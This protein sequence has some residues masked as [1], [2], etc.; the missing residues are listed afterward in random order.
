MSTLVTQLTKNITNIAEFTIQPE[1]IIRAG[2]TGLRSLKL[3]EEELS[4]VRT[5]FLHA[6]ANSLITAFALAVVALPCAYVLQ[7]KMLHPNSGDEGDGPRE[8]EKV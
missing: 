6:S 7:W 8:D 1:D 2:V 4:I 5:A 3:N